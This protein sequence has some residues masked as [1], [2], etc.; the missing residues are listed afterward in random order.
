MFWVDARPQ[1][2]CC[3]F[4]DADTLRDEPELFQCDTCPVSLAIDGLERDNAEAWDVY[5]RLASRFVRE[6]GIG[7]RVFDGIVDGW[8]GDDIEELV[9]RL[10]IIHDVLA[11]PP[12][13]D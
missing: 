7:G 1:L 3:R 8:D 11:P 5:R 9:T 10:D 2:P 6:A 12:Q 4:A 13:S